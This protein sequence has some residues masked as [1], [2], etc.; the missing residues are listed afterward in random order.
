MDSV[1]P[2]DACTLLSSA[3]LLL[4]TGLVLCL[5]LCVAIGASRPGPGASPLWHTFSAAP[6]AWLSL[7]SKGGW[8]TFREKQTN[9]EAV[10]VQVYRPCSFDCLWV[11]RL[12]ICGIAAVHLGFILESIC[13][14]NTMYTWRAPCTGLYVGS[15]LGRF[16]LVF[17]C[18]E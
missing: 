5:G 12:S 6:P 10:G 1:F 4:C 14:F 13:L 11:W 9:M 18:A 15:S 17:L 7:L 8:C 2:V 16:L 3:L